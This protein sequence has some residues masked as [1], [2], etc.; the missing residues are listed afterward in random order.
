MRHPTAATI[1]LIAVSVTAFPCWS[2]DTTISH[3]VFTNPGARSIALGGAFAAIADDATAAFANPAG[4]VQILRPEISAEIRGTGSS[5][6]FDSALSRLS[7]RLE[8][9][10]LR[11]IHISWGSSTSHSMVRFPRPANSPSGATRE[12]PRFRSEKA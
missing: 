2:Q 3:V 11:S 9:G 12:P 10:P 7:S 6:P 1:V 8:T 4:L 5:G